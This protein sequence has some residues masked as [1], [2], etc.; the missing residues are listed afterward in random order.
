MPSRRPAKIE[1]YKQL[2]AVDDS[3]SAISIGAFDFGRDKRALDFFVDV[4]EK[5]KDE[6]TYPD[7]DIIV[8]IHGYGTAPPLLQ[9]LSRIGQVRG[10]IIKNSSGSRHPEV[11]RFL[12]KQG[13]PVLDWTKKK[14]KNGGQALI[15]ACE[16]ILRPHKPFIIVDHGGYFAYP[17]VQELFD[18]FPPS[19]LLGVTEYTANGHVRF[20]E[21]GLNDRPVISVGRSRIKE[22]A[23]VA[24]AKLIVQAAS[25]HVMKHNAYLYDETNTI[26][27]IGY[28]RMGT[29][30]ARSIAASGF[31]HLYVNEIDH[32]AATRLEGLPF[33]EKE[34]L[35]RHANILFCATGQRAIRPDEWALLRDKTVIFTATSPDDELDLDAL[36]KQ[37]VITFLRHEGDDYEY[38]VNATGH[39][40]YLPFNGEAANVVYPSGV[41]DPVIYLPLAAQLVATVLLAQR[42]HEYSAKIND[43]PRRYEN[44]TAQAWREHFGRPMFDV[45]P[46]RP[47]FTGHASSKGTRELDA[48]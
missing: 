40:I 27:V 19:R 7:I 14:F 4:I 5:A 29:T 2:K 42:A 39:R 30:I 46:S 28:G 21:L 23:D 3:E 15:D 38:R 6:A 34:E 45:M 13:F 16:G 22:A 17:Q 33:A 41:T 37:K 43:L 44:M 8:V 31:R 11:G 20:K 32:V 26:G 1:R 18:H 47:Q 24:A 9:S 48:S 35:L 12:K 10:V 36:I 25:D